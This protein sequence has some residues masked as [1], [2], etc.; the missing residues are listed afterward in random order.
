MIKVSVII[1]VFNAEKYLGV[2]L[3]SILIQ[4][5]KDFEVIVV[6][7]CSTDNSVAVAE[8]FLEKFGGRLKIFSLSENTG[9]PGLPR[10]VALNYAGGKYIFFAD[11]DD[12][13]INSTLEGLFNYAENFSA[14]VVYTDTCFKCGEEI[15]PKSLEF[16]SYAKEKIFDGKPYFE[17]EILN[18]RIEKFLRFEFEWTPWLKFSRRDFL[19]GNDI[20]F[21]EAKTSEDGVWT[22]ELLCTAKKFL[23]IHEPFYVLRTNK[24]SITRRKRL[25]EDW[26]ALHTSSL[27]KNIDSLAKF[28]NRFDFFQKNSS[29]R[30][31]ILDY[32]ISKHLAQ[33]SLVGNTLNTRELYEVFLR[34][35]SNSNSP[36][37]NAYLFLLTKLYQNEMRK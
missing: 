17:T 36:A 35:F 32:F 9:T 8:S 16:V 31:T 15:V 30:M 13:I 24:N 11:S 3:E 4:T 5:L 18:E 29:V 12:F 25:P 27:I 28:M 33:I 14:D 34:E 26:A 6:D 7:D 1:P 20:T 19:I 37:L 22:F 10:N 21:S 23:H 2:C